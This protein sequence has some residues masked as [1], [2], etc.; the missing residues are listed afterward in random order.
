MS[1]VIKLNLKQGP[2]SFDISKTYNEEIDSIINQFL[3]GHWHSK[4]QLH[5]QLSNES[6]IKLHDNG[7]Y[8]IVDNENKVLHFVSNKID[9]ISLL[10]IDSRQNTSYNHRIT[11]ARMLNCSDNILELLSGKE[12]SLFHSK[13]NFGIGDEC[14]DIVKTRDRSDDMNINTVNDIGMNL[15]KSLY[16]ICVYF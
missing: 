12:F 15:L 3:C 13:N 2:I 16:Q 10:E 4:T 5:E 11:K 7:V 1:S 8:F 9:I 14:I 6:V